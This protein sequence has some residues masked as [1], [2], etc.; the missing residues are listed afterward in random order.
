MIQP[1][2]YDI[3]I[4]QGA[5]WEKSFQFFTSSG[6]AAN[7]TGATVTAELWTQGKRA[8][9]ATFTVTYVN[10]ANGEFK[11]SLTDAVTFSLPTSGYY[12][13]KV[14]DAAGFS[15]YWVRGEAVVE[16]GYTE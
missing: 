1:G 7:L 2:R 14:T 6:V 9:L 12:D 15:S 5:D 8:K 10:R 4:Q 3:V 11:L 16:T 13:I